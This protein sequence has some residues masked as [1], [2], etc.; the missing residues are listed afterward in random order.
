MA[1]IFNYDGREFPDPD[2]LLSVEEV[3]GQLAEFFLLCGISS[4][5]ISWSLIS[6]HR[7]A[8]D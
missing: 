2:P 5:G 4:C 3:R 8:L 7:N 6:A 1:R